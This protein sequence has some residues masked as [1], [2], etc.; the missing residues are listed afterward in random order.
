M[1]FIILGC[2][3]SMGVPR[4]DGDFG[5][6]NPNEKKIIELD[7]QLYKKQ[8]ENNILIDT[9]PDLSQQLISNKI[10]KLIKFFILICMQIK[11]MV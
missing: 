3:S 11:L 2:G 1:K 9:S 8:E 6:C 10:K 7:V 5:N 4:S